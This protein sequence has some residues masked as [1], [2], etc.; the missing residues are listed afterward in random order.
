MV[1]NEFVSA[2]A[3]ITIIIRNDADAGNQ[4][5]R[6]NIQDVPDQGRKIVPVLPAKDIRKETERERK[7]IKQDGGFES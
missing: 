5:E 2:T 1:E 4:G 6:D 7:N 3:T